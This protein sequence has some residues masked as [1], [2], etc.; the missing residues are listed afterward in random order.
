MM[1][2]LRN[3]SMLYRVPAIGALDEVSGVRGAVVVWEGDTIRYAG[4]A[5]ELP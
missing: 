2:L 4:S 1:K 3:I 5:A